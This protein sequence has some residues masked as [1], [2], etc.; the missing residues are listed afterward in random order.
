MTVHA[1]IPGGL[2]RVD[3]VLL[4]GTDPKPKRPVVVIA[5]A[6]PGLPTVRV[7]ARTSDI[8]AKGVA[9]PAN[10]SLGLT[11]PGVFGFQF[12]RSLDEKYFKVT[13]S[14]EYLGMLEDQYFEQILHWWENG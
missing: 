10:A 9:H 7:L 6:P 1:P 4:T 12:L 8:H 11:L 14:V 5:P 13:S 2:Y 3:T